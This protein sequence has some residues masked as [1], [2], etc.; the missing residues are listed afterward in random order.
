MAEP[1]A[2]VNDI[3]VLFRPL[4]DAE[5]ERAEALLP[6]V[7]D[8]L[9][10]C[11]INVGKDLDQ[12]LIE[13]PTMVSVAKIVTVDIISRIL[14]QDTNGE[15]MTQESQTAL[16]YTWSGTYAIQGGGIEAS[17]M[18]NDLKRLGLQRQQIGAMQ[19][20]QRS[21]EQP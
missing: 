5:T 3:K 16:G 15:P 12:M 2:T 4:T 8:A 21:K 11:A 1:F 7:S 18:Y 13:Q 19:L 6:L 20:W 10:Q 9:R 17:I 14:R